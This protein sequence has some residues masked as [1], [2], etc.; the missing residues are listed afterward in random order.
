MAGSGAVVNFTLTG[1]HAGNIGT[2]TTGISGTASF[3]YTGATA[4]TDTIR[5]ISLGATG[6]ATKVWLAAPLPDLA[7]NLVLSFGVCSNGLKATLCPVDGALS[8]DHDGN[9]YAAATVV[10]TN[11]CK[12]G[13]VP[14]SCKFG[15]TLTVTT[16]DWGTLPAH[17]LAFYLSTDNV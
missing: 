16:F 5:A 9:A 7:V 11:G 14:P 6:I 10:L 8:L 1:P 4:G 2:A 3:T 15:G 13:R 17:P 12:P